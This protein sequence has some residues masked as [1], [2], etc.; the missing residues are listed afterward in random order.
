MPEFILIFAFSLTR[1]SFLAYRYIQQ[2]IKLTYMNTNDNQPFG[3]QVKGKNYLIKVK[4][5]VLHFNFAA[6]TSRGALQSKPT[7]FIQVTDLITQDSG[8]GECSPLVGLSPEFTPYYETNLKL[9]CKKLAALKDLNDLFEIPDIALFPSVCF[10]FETAIKD[11]HSKGEKVLFKN[12]FSSK[13]KALLINGLI[14]MGDYDFM[15]QQMKDKVGQGFTCIKLK[16]GGIDFDKE[17]LILKQL[18]DNFSSE[19][20]SIRLDAN[21]AFS[22]KTAL[23]KLEKLSEFEVH[24]IEQPIRQGQIN[25]MAQLC[26]HSPIPIALDEELIGINGSHAKEKLLEQINPQYIILKPSLLGGFKS[27][28]ELIEVAAQNKVGWWITSALESNIGLN[29]IA[30][31]TANYKNDLPQGLGTGQLY[32]NNIKSPLNIE[33]GKLSLLGYEKWEEINF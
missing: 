15:L 11:L 28:A 33:H 17:C 13:K 21:G 25:E 4:K 10:G 14:W 24:S 30:Q 19:Q 32:N 20:I 8:I 12:D 3:F 18:R 9:F 27:S 2:K 7:Y 5:H 16:I 22:P 29:A 31:F 26:K 1:K 6:K 23:A